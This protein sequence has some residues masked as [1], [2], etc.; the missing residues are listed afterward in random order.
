MSS[1]IPTLELSSLLFTKNWLRTH[2]IDSD[3]LSAIFDCIS[4]GKREIYLLMV[5]DADE[6]WRVENTRCQVS[7]RFS[8][9]SAVSVSRISPTKT[10]LGSSLIADLKALANDQVSHPNSLCEIRH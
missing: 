10:M 1:Y 3:N 5:V 9:A 8:A 7:A 6:V 4:G 2:D